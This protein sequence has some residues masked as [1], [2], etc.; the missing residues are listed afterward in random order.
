MFGN[1]SRV[2]KK[3]YAEWNDITSTGKVTTRHITTIPWY[4]LDKPCDSNILYRYSGI[5]VDRRNSRWHI[6]LLVLSFCPTLEQS[7]R[8]IPKITTPSS[9]KAAMP[10]QKAAQKN[11]CSRSRHSM[12]VV[13]SGSRKN[14][15]RKLPKSLGISSPWSRKDSSANIIT[16]KKTQCLELCPSSTNSFFLLGQQETDS[17]VR[18]GVSRSSPIVGISAEIRYNASGKAK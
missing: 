4:I 11:V 9:I 3:T 5:R 18:F 17:W 16:R 10:D 15:R 14:S 8:E 12:A 7:R 13:P 1:G 2:G 6:N